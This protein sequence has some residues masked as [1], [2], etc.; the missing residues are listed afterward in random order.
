MVV[1]PFFFARVELINTL[2]HQL[3]H[4]CLQ[5][6]LID[7]T[8]NGVDYREC[9]RRLACPLPSLTSVFLDPDELRTQRELWTIGRP[10]WEFPRANGAPITN[11]AR[12]VRHNIRLKDHS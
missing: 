2:D 8:F 10:S 4:D 1:V 12:E 9:G 5:A 11:V 3:F 7:W 6:D